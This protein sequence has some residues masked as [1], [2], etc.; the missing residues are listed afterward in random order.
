MFMLCNFKRHP[1]RELAPFMD[2][3]DDLREV[4]FHELNETEAARDASIERLRK[5]LERRF[6]TKR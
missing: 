6:V 1:S 2:L 5:L 3:P 4:A